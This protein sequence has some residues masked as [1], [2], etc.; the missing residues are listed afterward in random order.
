VNS[1]RC[2]ARLPLGCR[3]YFAAD[4]TTSQPSVSFGSPSGRVISRSAGATEALCCSDDNVIGRFLVRVS[5]RLAGQ[6]DAH[7]APVALRD[8]QRGEGLQVGG[9]VGAFERDLAPELFTGALVDRSEERRVGKGC[10]SG[11]WAEY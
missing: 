1:K 6:L 11:R 4:R 5:Q 7:A 3:R 2:P 10:R 9:Q 8:A